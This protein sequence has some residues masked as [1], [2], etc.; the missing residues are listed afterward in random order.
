MTLQNSADDFPENGIFG[1]EQWDSTQMIAKDAVLAI[2]LLLQRIERKPGHR[3]L[4]KAASDQKGLS[5][6]EPEE[7]RQILSALQR[8][9][10]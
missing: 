3:H 9:A 5:P 4:M 7:P 6:D 8:T 1:Q 2:R 10:I